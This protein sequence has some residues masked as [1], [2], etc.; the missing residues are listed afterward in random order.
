LQ[1]VDLIELVKARCQVFFSLATRRKIKLECMAGSQPI[2]LVLA[3]PDRLAQVLDNLLDNAIRHSPENSAITITIKEANDGVEC[4]VSDQGAGI[5]AQHLPFIF[6]R[7]YRVDASRSRNRKD[8][9]TGLG[10][11]IARALIHAQSGQISA[12]SVEGEG[13][14]ISFWLPQESNVS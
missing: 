7:F 8:G 2:P 4:F 1:S 13:T 5:P 6:E 11:A 3:D 9:G 14:T 10:L 12:Q